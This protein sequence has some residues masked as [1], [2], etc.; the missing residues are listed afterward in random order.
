M[1][2][3]KKQ[4]VEQLAD[5]LN[6]PKG[7]CSEFYDAFLDIIS[8]SLRKKRQV[9]FRG[10]GKLTLKRL[11]RRTMRSLQTGRLIELPKRQ[12]VKFSPSPALKERLNP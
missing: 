9:V 12:T 8:E 5:R 4:I 3:T 10:F 2:T 11:K 1:K 6:L 7:V